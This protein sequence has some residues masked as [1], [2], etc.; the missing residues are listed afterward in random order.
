MLRV[1]A[2]AKINLHL[3]ILGR[4]G[5]GYHEL[6][7]VFQ[8]IDLADELLIGKADKET[9]LDVPGHE[10]LE[11]DS[12]LVIRAVRWLEGKAGRRLPVAVRLVK[13]IPT[14]AGLGGGSTDAAA[15]LL[16][17]RAL[18]RLELTDSEL[19]DGAAGLGADVPFF[20]V[21]GTAVGEGVGE[22]LSPI[23]LP[24]DYTLVLVNPRF[25]VST[26]TVFRHFSK[27]LTGEPRNGRL[28]WII[29]RLRGIGELLHNDLQTTAE[30]LYPE[31]S[32]VLRALEG[33]GAEQVLMTG[34][35]PTVFA[36]AREGQTEEMISRMPEK[37][38]C[39]SARPVGTGMVIE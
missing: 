32:E 27:T 2:P 15:A 16:G 8:A 37:W 9:T 38:K 6:E 17:V 12:N 21:G 25:S 30:R 19:L 26:A 20:L 5:D 31:I 4:R 29:D 34:S 1:L 7:T 10:D 22:R 3:R 28:W 24:L 39:F 33:A 14:A 23:A 35:G 13:N 11:N 36:V 18:Y